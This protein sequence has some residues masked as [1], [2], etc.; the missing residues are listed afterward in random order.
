MKHLKNTTTYKEVLIL[1]Q[2]TNLK[3]LYVLGIVNIMLLN[4]IWK[5]YKRKKLHLT[6]IQ[7]LVTHTNMAMTIYEEKIIVNNLRKYKSI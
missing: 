3:F 5:S 4:Q 2:C 6:M 7:A 1:K